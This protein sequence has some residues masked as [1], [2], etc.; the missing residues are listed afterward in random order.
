M[1]GIAAATAGAGLTYAGASKQADAA[2]SAAQ[3]Q[4]TEQKNALDFQ[5]QEWNTQQANEAP[6]LHAGQSAVT[7]LSS[8]MAPGGQLSQGWTGQFQAPTADQAAATPGY[9]FQLQQ[10]QQALERSAA[11]RGGV[12]SGGT[13]KALDQYGQGLAST[14]YQQAYNNALTQYQQSY[15]QFQ[16]NQSNLFNRNASLAGLGQTTAGQLGAQGQQAAGNVGNLSLTGGQQIGQDWQN[17]A[18]QTASG[19]N[20]IGSG[21]N[22]GINNLGNALTLASL[23]PKTSSGNT[24]QTGIGPGITGDEPIG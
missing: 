9:Q 19:Y 6:F 22:S 14:N 20:A 11:A 4:A 23:L 24:P 2:Q 21:I 8:L 17:A 16:Q 15:N 3:L 1:G 5:K 7:N 13:A 18:Y 12:L 10:G